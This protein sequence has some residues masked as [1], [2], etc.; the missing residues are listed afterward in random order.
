MVTPDQVVVATL[1]CDRLERNLYQLTAEM[2]LPSRISASSLLLLALATAG[3]V[4][5]EQHKATAAALSEQVQALEAQLQTTQTSLQQLS[6]TQSSSHV[7][8]VE[9]L[10]QLSEQIS[11][12]PEELTGICPQPVNTVTNV[13]DEKPEIRKVVVT[14]DKMLVGELERVWVDPP[15]TNLVARMDT[16]ASSSSLHAEDLVKFE[17][18]GDDWVRFNVITDDGVATLE[19]RV[20]RYVRVYQQ[21]DADGSRRPVV[22]LRIH[23]GDIQ[24]TFEFTLADRGHLEHQFLLGRNFLTDIALVDVSKQ[25]VQPRYEPNKK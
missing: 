23:L 25:F 11:A 22:N 1:V 19:R 10:T 15:G 2:N 8:S 17:R 4:S 20:E 7:E 18:D 3:C 13:C 9:Q 21:A 6:Q 5:P 16:G 14:D 24:D 12:L